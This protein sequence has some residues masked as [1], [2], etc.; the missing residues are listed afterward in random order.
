MTFDDWWD[1]PIDMTGNP[2]RQDCA[3]YWAWAGWMAGVKSEQDRCAQIAD[4]HASCEGI[5]Q[6]IAA[7]IRSDK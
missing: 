4:A 3:A 7:E 1:S 5:A 6:V 2:Y